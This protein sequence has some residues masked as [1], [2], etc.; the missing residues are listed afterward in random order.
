MDEMLERTY[1]DG[2]VLGFKVGAITASGICLVT[3]VVLMAITD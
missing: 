1:W 2:W 3:L